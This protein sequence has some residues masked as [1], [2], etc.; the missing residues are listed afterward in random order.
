[1]LSLVSTVCVKH[2]SSCMT[3]VLSC[4]MFQKTDLFLYYGTTSYTQARRWGCTSQQSCDKFL[5][6]WFYFDIPQRKWWRDMKRRRDGESCTQQICCQQ[7]ARMSKLY[8]TPNQVKDCI[9]S[10][11]G[12]SLGKYGQRL[13]IRKTTLVLIGTFML[14]R[15]PLNCCVQQ[16]LPVLIVS[17]DIKNK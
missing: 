9:S 4:K 14:F 5:R 1:M 11:K 6:G 7:S 15:L 16:P 17:W 10:F 13:L 8:L 12:T 2:P 3:S